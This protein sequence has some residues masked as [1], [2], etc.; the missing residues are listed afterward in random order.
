MT[1]RR[2]RFF[3]K[4]LKLGVGSHKNSSKTGYTCYLFNSRWYSQKDTFR[5]M[6]EFN[7]I[8]MGQ[9]VDLVPHSKR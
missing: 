4:R 8:E 9:K 3:V 2:P 6:K 1:L 5:F 7:V